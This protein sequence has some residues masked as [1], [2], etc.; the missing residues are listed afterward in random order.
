MAD[1]NKSRAPFDVE[2][3]AVG[4]LA[5]MVA[6]GNVLIDK[7]VITQHEL[8]ARLDQVKDA[9]RKS[10]A[11]EDALMAVEGIISGLKQSVPGPKGQLQ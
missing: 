8:L 11:G 5:S 4:Q 6:L 10:S 1:E 9:I 2:G 7:G 3:F